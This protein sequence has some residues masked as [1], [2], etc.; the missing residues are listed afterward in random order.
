VAD[1]NNNRVQKFDV[2]GNFLGKY[3][4]GQFDNPISLTV[5]PR[6]NY[7]YVADTGNKRIQKLDTN[8]NYI[9]EWGSDGNSPGQIKRPTGIA[10]DNNG[11]IFVLDKDNGNV[12]TFVVA[13]QQ[14]A[15]QTKPVTSNDNQNEDA[16]IKGDSENKNRKQGND[17][18]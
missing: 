7:V 14:S 6:T 13:N 16:K 10:T 17:G 8:G 18:R 5:E 12:Q 2:N 4:N 1:T 11:R 3:A 15:V 9:L